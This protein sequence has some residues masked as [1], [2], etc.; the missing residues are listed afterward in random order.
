MTAYRVTRVES[1]R[2]EP[3]HRSEAWHIVNGHAWDQSPRLPVV[4]MAIDWRDVPDHR[5]IVRYPI[6]TSV[7]FVLAIVLGACLAVA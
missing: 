4:P 2:V 1:V 6:L 3:R 7:A 5:P